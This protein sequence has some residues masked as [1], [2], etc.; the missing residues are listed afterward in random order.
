MSSWRMDSWSLLLSGRVY[1]VSRADKY[2]SSRR[3]EER[4]R[5]MLQGEAAYSQ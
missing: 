5:S 3:R 4:D 1:M 2:N